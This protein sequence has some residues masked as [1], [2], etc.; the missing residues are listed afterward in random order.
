MGMSKQEI[1]R[2]LDEIIDF[3]GVERY[4]DT[5]VKRYSTGMNVRLG[6]AIAA[7][8]EPD[9]LVVDEVL[10]VGD[11]EF[12]KKAIGKM[13]DVS[14]SSGRTV[15]FVSHNMAAIRELCSLGILLQNGIIVFE[16]TQL[17]SINKYQSLTNSGFSFNYDGELDKAI[18]DDNIK[19]LMFSTK[20]LAGNSISISSGFELSLVILNNLSNRNIAVTIELRTMDETVIFHQGIWLFQNRD[21]KC[22]IYEVKGEMPSNLLNTGIYKFNIIIAESF[23]SVFLNVTD[24]IRLE[25]INESILGNNLILPGIIRAPLIL[26]FNKLEHK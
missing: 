18:G 22:G 2:K 20:S 8:L 1:R 7:Y 19:I 21:S 9:I 5:P 23:H 3:S 10:A 12:Q 15:L 11:A 14:K 13:Q 25:I 6:F 4:I 26:N 16:G 24:I 17:E